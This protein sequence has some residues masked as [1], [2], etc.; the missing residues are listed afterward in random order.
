MKH[1][2]LKEL[3]RALLEL[4][5][6]EHRGSCVTE[7]TAL[8]WLTLHKSTSIQLRASHSRRLSELEFC[9]FVSLHLS[10]LEEA[11]ESTQNAD[12]ESSSAPEIK[13]KQC[14]WRPHIPV[15]Q[16]Y[17]DENDTPPY[18][19]EGRPTSK[20]LASTTVSSLRK[21]TK[22]PSESRMSEA[23]EKLRSLDPANNSSHFLFS[24]WLKGH[25]TEHIKLVSLTL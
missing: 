10:A 21:P 25:Q 12:V 9:A 18:F 2:E 1:Q 6:C 13:S 14:E 22:N 8:R 23:V 3:Y 15:T 17:A 19:S 24:V 7:L 16:L 11:T 20:G 4:E 5:S